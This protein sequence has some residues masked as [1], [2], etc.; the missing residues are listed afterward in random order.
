MIK[1]A[2]FLMFNR[3]L[4]AHEAQRYNLVTE[5]LPHAEFEQKAW[6][7]VEEFSKLPRESLLESR[8]VLRSG[9]VDALRKANKQEVEVLVGRW[10]S[11]EFQRV[12][13][14]FWMKPKSKM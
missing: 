4:D 12:I 5:V 14:E 13:T 7:R 6:Q 10:A 9:E 1:A 3:K 2:E 11:A 8:R